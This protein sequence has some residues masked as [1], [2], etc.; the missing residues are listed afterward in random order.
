MKERVVVTK[1]NSS[2]VGINLRHF[3]IR[4]TV[5]SRFWTL[6]TAPLWSLS[7]ALFIEVILNDVCAPRKTVVEQ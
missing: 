4:S 2:S 3:V 1:I 6:T 5:T 7:P